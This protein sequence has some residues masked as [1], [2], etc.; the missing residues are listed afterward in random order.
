MV[1]NAR[2][3]KPADCLD[4]MKPKRTE[5]NWQLCQTD[6]RRENDGKQGL[7]LVRMP[8][9]RVR[10]GSQ[11]ANKRR[12]TQ[13]GCFQAL[14][15]TSKHSLFAI[16]RFPVGNLFFWLIWGPWPHFGCHDPTFGASKQK[17]QNGTVHILMSVNP[18]PNCAWSLKHDTFSL[19]S[20]L[21][22]AV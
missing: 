6:S 3:N 22:F 14:N 15:L 16:M 1:P 8:L 9:S 20:P 2:T 5:K 4:Q 19:F 21:S 11:A 10:K 13:S 18:C 12:N 17:N 7:S